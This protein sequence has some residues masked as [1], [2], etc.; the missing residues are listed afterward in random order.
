MATPRVQ[1]AVHTRATKACRIT[2]PSGD[3]LS[4][5][6]GTVKI[7]DGP[8]L[9]FIH[10]YMFGDRVIKRKQAAKLF[11]ETA[12]SKQRGLSLTRWIDERLN[13]VSHDQQSST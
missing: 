10:N 6:I 12:L 7:P 5:M 8:E 3:R 11:R 9:W 2:L 13:Q 4:V 1:R